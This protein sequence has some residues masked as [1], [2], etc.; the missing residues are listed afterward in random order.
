MSEEITSTAF[1][2]LDER[3]QRFIWAQGWEALRDAQE[4]AIPL[5][6][7]GDCDVIIAAATAAGKTEA[8]FFPALTHLLAL[9]EPGLIVYVSPLKALIN[10]QFGRLDLLCELLEVPVWPWHGDISSSTKTRFLSKREGVLLITPESMEALLCNRGSSV[11]AVFER[12]AFFI[13]DELHAFIGSERGKQMQSLL[14]RIETNLGRRVPRIGLSATLGDMQLAASF[15]RPGN[16]P[17]PILIESRES[18]AE[19]KIL[20]K[21]YEEPSFVQSSSHDGDTQDSEETITSAHVAS[22]LFKVLRGSN[23]LIFPNS[24]REVERYTYLLNKMCATE[25]VPNEFWPH[26]GSLSKE[27]RS[28]TEAALKQKEHPA[29]AICTNTLELGI[30]IGAVRSVV[31][32]GPPPSVASLRQRLGRSGRRKGEAAILRGYCIE[33]A[34]DTRSSFSTELRLSTVQMAAMISLLT[35]NWF[36]PPRAH[37]MHLSTLIQQILSLIAQRG[38]A[39]IGQAY[40]QLCGLGMPFEGVSKEEFMVLVRHLGSKELLTQDSS[41]LLLHGRLGEKFV[42]HYSFYAAFNVDEEFRIIN[43]GRLLGTLPISQML[44]VGQRILFA[45][46]TWL[47]EDIDEAQKSIHVVRTRGG[48]PPSFSGGSGRVHTMVRQEMRKILESNGKLPYLDVV[49]QRFLDEAREAYIH[50]DLANQVLIEQGNELL[51]LT[52]HGDAANETIACFLRRRGYVA[53]LAG[54]GVEVIK[55]GRSSDD[56]LAALLDA[57]VDEPPSF[58]I[59]LKDATNLQQQKWDWAL[60]DNLLRTAY[61]SLYLDIDEA[62]RWIKCLDTNQVRNKSFSSAPTDNDVSGFH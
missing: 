38:G 16:G 5:L 27:I 6:I 36:E 41:G 37:G 17:A 3:I 10:D 20:V 42:N 1:F 4:R 62:F 14:H 7:K 51:V 9:K 2:L 54:P 61:A 39:T 31:Q 25:Q 29:T 26:H 8:A 35:K 49:A 56:I 18:G 44:T 52:W 19:L 46:K 55:A 43:G 33:H 13:I 34:V 60:P 40:T 12:T 11:S 22:H 48:V 50:K 28:E 57:A 15:L 58:D 23:N 32:I 24:R 47:V 59:L 45:G 21:G 30:D 53:T